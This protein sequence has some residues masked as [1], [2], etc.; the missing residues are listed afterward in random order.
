MEGDIDFI[1]SFCCLCSPQVESLQKE[2]RKRLES[3]SDSKKNQDRF[4]EELHAREQEL[5]QQLSSLKFDKQRLEDTIYRLKT[6]SMTSSVTLKQ[7]EDNI[8]GEKSLNVRVNAW[9]HVSYPGGTFW[10]STLL[11]AFF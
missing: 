2:S 8:E 5:L 10:M 7:L 1:C 3:E 6:E 4:V 9:R 11:L